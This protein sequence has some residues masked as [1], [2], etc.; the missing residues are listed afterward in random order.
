MVFYSN[1]CIFHRVFLDRMVSWDGSDSQTFILHLHSWFLVNV[2]LLNLDTHST[3]AIISN[4][5]LFKLSHFKVDLFLRSYVRLAHTKGV[6]RQ[7]PLFEYVFHYFL[8]KISIYGKR[9]H[10]WYLHLNFINI[11]FMAF[12]FL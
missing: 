3:K 2:F 9:L 6:P 7:N 1:E 5:I 4:C 12:Q 11:R 10:K 8:P